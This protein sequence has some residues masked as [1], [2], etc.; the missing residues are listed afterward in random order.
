M[1]SATLALQSRNPVD[2]LQLVDSTMRKVMNNSMYNYLSFEY[3]KHLY[4]Y[5]MV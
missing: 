4:D 5:K 2:D 3:S 1:I